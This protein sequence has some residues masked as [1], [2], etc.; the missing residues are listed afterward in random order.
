MVKRQDEILARNSAHWDKVLTKYARFILIRQTSTTSDIGMVEDVETPVDNRYAI[1]GKLR[2]LKVYEIEKVAG[3]FAKGMVA[4]DY[5]M[6]EGTYVPQDDDY[7]TPVPIGRQPSM[8]Y[9]IITILDNRN[10][11]E[12][13][14]IVQPIGEKQ[15]DNG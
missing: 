2:S 1:W 3:F 13:K 6:P 10:P 4:F 9:R 14:C 11:F 12:G 5:K 8:R 15:H 7:V